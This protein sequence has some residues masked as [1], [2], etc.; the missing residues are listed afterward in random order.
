MEQKTVSKVYEGISKIQGKIAKVGLQKTKAA[1]LPYFFRGIDDVINLITHLMVEENIIMAPHYEVI[2]YERVPQGTK[3]ITAVILRGTF[4]FYSTL[5]GSKIECKAIG[6]A[7]DFSDKAANKAMSAALKYCLLQ[8]FMIPTDEAKD[9][10][11]ANPEVLIIAETTKKNSLANTE[12]VIID[13]DK[14]H[15]E[16]LSMVMAEINDLEVG[17]VRER[18][19][20]AL[21]K[22]KS[23]Q[24]LKE[25]LGKI[26]SLKK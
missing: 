6:E 22:A 11:L 19:L 20:K 13:N 15:E 17:V 1:A 5:D 16:A 9:N 3:F 18:A 26:K 7:L 25:L 23:P 21:E 24:D 12:P 4:T 10:E 8:T 14:E 2:K